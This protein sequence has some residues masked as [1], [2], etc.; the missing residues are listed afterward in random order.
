MDYQGWSL[1]FCR[2]DR[3]RRRLIDVVRVMRDWLAPYGGF[4]GKD[5]LDFGAGE[6]TQALG[7]A[8]QCSPRRIAAADIHEKVYN[9]RAQAKEHIGLDHLPDSLE[10]TKIDS[11]SDLRALGDFDIIYSWSVFEHVS[12]DIIGDAF[13]KLRRVLRPGGV[14]FLQTT[15]LYY[16]AEGSHLKPW[17][18]APWAHLSMQHDLLIDALRKKAPSLDLADNLQWVYESLNKATA[19]QIIRA[20]QGAGFRIVRDYRTLDEIEPPPAL[21]EIYT[22]E[23]LT[24][25]QLVFLAEPA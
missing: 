9:C 8:L 21:L 2:N 22:K 17:I 11:G 15:P 19:A 5:V 13:A 20:A 1:D 7:I 25:N 16:S 18:P 12:Q 14:M 3:Y 6:A 10:L 24:T 23:A 4:E